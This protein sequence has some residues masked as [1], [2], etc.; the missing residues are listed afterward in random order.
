MLDKKIRK[1]YM[2]GIKGTGMSSLA[3]LLKNIGYQITGSDTS[4]KFFTEDQLIKNNIKYYENF[5]PSHINVTKPDIII[6]ST[7]YNERNLEV[8]RAKILKIPI[9]T[10]PEIVGSLSKKFNSIGICGSHGKTTTTSMLGLVMKSN[11]RTI[12]LTGTIAE[13]LNSKVKNPKFFIFEADEYQDKFQYYQ[14]LNIILTNVDFDHPDFFKNDKHYFS[15]FYRLVSKILK[16]GGFILFNYDNK[17]AC[18]IFKT[19]NGNFSSYGFHKDSDFII[20]QVNSD[21]NQFS[22]LKRNKKF[23]DIKLS[24]Y[25]KHNILN[26]AAS[27]IMAYRLGIKKEQIK[28]TLKQFYGIKR[29]MEKINNNN[30]IIIDDYGHHPTEIVA[31]LAA[32]RNKYYDKYIVTVFHPHT[33]SRTEMFVKDFGRS[34]KNSDLTIV[35]NIYPSA[36]ETS[37]NIHATNLVKEIGQNKCKAI[38]MATINDAA[39]YI[40][41]NVDKNSVILPIG[42]GHVWKIHKL[43]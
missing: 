23:L 28:K 33:F 3:V 38:Y 42:A 37:G 43:L 30:Y 8:S 10:Y 24:V 25:G 32:L 2:I 39:E 5:N 35:L 4:E 36:R 21:L 31:T 13:F 27:A 15:V 14:P 29:R 12:T 7:A 6:V 20:T 26:A 16:N 19:M 9:A 11:E 1:I 40:K 22:I 34:F 17:N 41:N 18:R